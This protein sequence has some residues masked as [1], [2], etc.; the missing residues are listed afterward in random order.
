MHY[1][2]RYTLVYIRCHVVISGPS[3]F[4][5]IT[6]LEMNLWIDPDPYAIENKCITVARW[7]VDN[8]VRVIRN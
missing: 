6:K 4:A 3:C 2:L 5:V 1:A 8:N 7:L